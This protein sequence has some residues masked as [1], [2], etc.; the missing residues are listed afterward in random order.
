MSET[1]DHLPDVLQ[2]IADCAGLGVALSLAKE[3]GG[4]RITIPKKVEGS[5]LAKIVGLDAAQKIV[6]E[7]GHGQCL[8]PCGPVA[9]ERG[10]REVARRV[11]KNKGTAVEA[12]LAAGISERTVWRLKARL[13]DEADNA[14]PLPLFQ[15]EPKKNA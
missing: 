14:A 1:F 12:A 7:L 15:K 4:V 8:I 2:R 11:L 6:K 5:D 9:G 10:R 3:R 13:K